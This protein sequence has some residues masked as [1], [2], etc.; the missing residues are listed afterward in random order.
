MSFRQVCVLVL[1]GPLFLAFAG[2]ALM[3]YPMLFVIGWLM[4]VKDVAGS[5]WEICTMP[6]RE[7]WLEIWKGL[8][9]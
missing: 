3:L 1:L 2:G 9:Q 4:G 5:T 6:P 8:D 7:M